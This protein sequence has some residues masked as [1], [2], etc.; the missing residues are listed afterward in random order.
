MDGDYYSPTH[1]RRIE[2]YAAPEEV[3]YIFTTPNIT[4]LNK[5]THKIFRNVAH[6]IHALIESKGIIILDGIGKHSRS[7]D[8][9]LELASILV[10]LCPDQFNVESD[11]KECG[12]TENEKEMH[13]FNFYCK[14]CEKF[15]IN[16]SEKYIKIRTHFHNRRNASFNKDKLEG[17]LFDLDWR[18]I[19][20]GNIDGIPRETRDTIREIAKLIVKICY[21]T[22]C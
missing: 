1:R 12:Y 19:K 10:V 11:S 17:E 7:T 5:L 21:G 20:K 6:S 15:D 3:A 13:P 9:L 8:S 16:S 2:E 4:K 14:E 18:V 22:K